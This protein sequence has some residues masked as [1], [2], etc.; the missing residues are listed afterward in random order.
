MT[1][2]L[3]FIET[4]R[5]EV[6]ILMPNEPERFPDEDEVSEAN[7]EFDDDEDDDEGDEDEITEEDEDIQ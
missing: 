6:L 1:G 4:I 5:P 3:P 2:K 7:D